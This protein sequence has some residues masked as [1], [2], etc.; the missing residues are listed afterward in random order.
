MSKKPCTSDEGSWCCA[1]RSRPP[2]T[3]P[4][5]WWAP[6]P[7]GRSSRLHSRSRTRFAR[8]QGCSRGR[9]WAE[10]WPSSCTSS[11]PWW[12]TAR[13]RRTRLRQHNYVY[14]VALNLFCYSLIRHCLFKFRPKDKNCTSTSVDQNLIMQILANGRLRYFREVVESWGRGL[15]SKVWEFS[16]GENYSSSWNFHWTFDTE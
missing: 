15:I 11:S 4:W 8:C 13:S 2:G 6:D 9:R 16:L 7:V 10:G 14:H 1:P 5:A 3:W 12:Y